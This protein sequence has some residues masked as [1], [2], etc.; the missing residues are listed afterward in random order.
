[1]IITTCPSLDRHRITRYHGIVTGGSRR[2]HPGKSDGRA[3]DL[4]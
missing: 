3:H 4:A 1:M 2:L